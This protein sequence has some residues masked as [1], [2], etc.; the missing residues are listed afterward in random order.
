MKEMNKA[1][2]PALEVKQPSAS[3][4]HVKKKFVP[5]DVPAN[6]SAPVT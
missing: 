1:I 2:A 3:L 4:S 6:P 5:K